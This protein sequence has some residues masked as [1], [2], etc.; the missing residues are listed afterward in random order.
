MVLLGAFKLIFDLDELWILTKGGI[1]LFRKIDQDVIEEQLFG[2][3][4]SA[5]STFSEN[6]SEGGLKSFSFS[7]KTYT[8]IKENNFIF[9]GSHAKKKKE[10]KISKELK[11][12]ATIFFSSYPNDLLQNIMNNWDGDVNVFSDFENFLSEDPE[13]KLR[14]IL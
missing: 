3:L 14:S 11:Y 8:L 12:I 9:V 1:V 7:D 13:D 6:L 4:M 5:L 10:K 2:A